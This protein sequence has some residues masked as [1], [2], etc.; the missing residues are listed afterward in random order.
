VSSDTTVLGLPRLPARYAGIVM[1]LLLSILMTMIVS[2]VSTARAVGFP[3]GFV[4][5]WAGAWAM[6]WI[7][8]FPTLLVLLPVVRRIT[9]AIVRGA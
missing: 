9:A 7:V 2:F 6:S 1:P 8:A 5:I 4:R 3:P